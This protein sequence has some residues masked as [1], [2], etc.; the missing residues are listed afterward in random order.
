MG[1]WDYVSGMRGKANDRHSHAWIKRGD[2]IIDITAD[3]FDEIKASVIVAKASLW[4]D[5]FDTEILHEAD[6][7]V[8]DPATIITLSSAYAN[9]LDT[10]EH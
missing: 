3:Q 7:H 5:S 10:L 9:I 6:F 2:I 1:S 8:Y 4:H